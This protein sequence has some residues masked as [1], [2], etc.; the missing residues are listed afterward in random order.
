MKKV[1]LTLMTLILTSCASIKTGNQKFLEI[2]SS[3][4]GAEVWLNDELVCQT[5]CRYDVTGSRNEIF[6]LALTMDG[7]R[8][9]ER[10]LEPKTHE[11]VK[12]DLILCLLPPVG[13]TML[14]I[15]Y[16]TGSLWTYNDVNAVL[17]RKIDLS[18]RKLP[19][20]IRPLTP[21]TENYIRNNFNRLKE[22]AF[23]NTSSQERI[24]TLA[25]MA[26]VDMSRLIGMISEAQNSEEL[27][28]F[29]KNN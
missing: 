10:K 14:G 25:S 2:N 28:D 3:P 22:E 16:Y 26:G 1:A 29:L 27:I 19:D 18:P 24:R 15:D 6:R 9:Y 12:A 21:E 5:P 17:E 11:A 4:E 20:I 13:M 7:Y 8:I 23:A